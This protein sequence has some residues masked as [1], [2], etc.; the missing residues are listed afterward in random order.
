V[1]FVVVRVSPDCRRVAH[2]RVVGREGV[3]RIRLG[4]RVG[5]HTLRP[6]TYRLVARAVPGGRKVVDARLVVARR[7]NRD[8]IEAARGADTCTPADGASNA[9]GAASAGSGAGGGP[10]TGSDASTAQSGARSKPA[11]HGGVL[12]ARFARRAVDAA[13]DVPL[14]LYGLALL[15]IILLAIG[16]FLP[17]AA[18]R[19]LATSMVVGMTGA[20]VL[21]I[22]MAAY[23]L[24]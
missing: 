5:R 12:A 24:L 16:A 19:G 6:G 9:L 11:R 2:F 18:P 15:S 21:L 4:P 20:A 7:A 8:E 1:R 22:A 17:K 13:R 10:S 23:V 14:W 3:N